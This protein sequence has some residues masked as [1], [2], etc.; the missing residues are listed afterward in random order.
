MTIKVHLVF[1]KPWEIQPCRTFN[2][3]GNPVET[4]GKQKSKSLF[5]GQSNIYEFFIL[6]IRLMW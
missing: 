4:V 2:S 5:L 3:D 6:E 1:P